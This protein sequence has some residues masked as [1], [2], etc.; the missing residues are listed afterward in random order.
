MVANPSIPPLP[1]TPTR[2]RPPP[3]I[4]LTGNTDID[5]DHDDDDNDNDNDAVVNYTPL[6]DRKKRAVSDRKKKAVG[7]DNPDKSRQ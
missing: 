6:G 3:V 2:L 1:T 5:D 7:V 4:D